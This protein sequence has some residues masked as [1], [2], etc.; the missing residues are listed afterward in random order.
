LRR[1]APKLR[2]KKGKDGKPL[3]DRNGNDV[4]EVVKNKAGEIVREPYEIKVLNTIDFKKSMHYNPFVY[5]RSEKDILKFTTALIANT[6]GEDAKSGE[7]FWTKAEVLLYCALI[8]YIWYEGQPEEKNMNTLVRF[9][10]AMEVREDDETYQ[11]G[12]DLLFEKLKAREPDH[13]AVRQY[14]K[15]RLAAGNVSCKGRFN[16]TPKQQAESHSRH[17]WTATAPPH[18]DKYPRRAGH[19]GQAHFNTNNKILKGVSL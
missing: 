16:Q 3:K 18:L 10:N 1:G 14:A 8:G 9:I 13:F 5:I 15:Y 19:I 6:K 11:N 12:V 7:D 2:V 4:M 17:E